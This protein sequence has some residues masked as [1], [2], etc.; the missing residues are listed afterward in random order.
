MKK[1]NIFLRAFLIYCLILILI[2]GAGLLVLRSFL[3]SYEASRPD[4]TVEEFMASRDHDFWLDGLQELIDAGFNEFTL[5]GAMLSDFGI[6]ENAEIS[7]RSNASDSKTEQS[8]DVRLGSSKICTLLLRSSNNVGFGLKSWVVSDWEFTMPGGADIRLS[9]PTGC[10]AEIN[11]VAVSADYITDVGSISLSLEHDFDIPPA[12]EIYEI[13]GMMGPA[14][15]KAFDADG[16]EL[17]AASVSANHV[18]FLPEPTQE[19]SFLALEGAEVYVNGQEITGNYCSPLDL[20][21]EGESSILRYE[22]QGLFGE[23]DIRVVQDE[24]L[25]EAIELPVGYCYIPGASEEIEGN[26]SEFLEGFIY[27]YVNFSANKDH[28]AEGNFAALSNYLLP[29]SELYTLIANTIENIAW[30]TTS[31][32][33]YNSISYFDLIPLGDERYICSIAYD[34]S[35]TLGP[36]ELEVKDGNLILV[37]KHDGRYRV[38]AMSAALQ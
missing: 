12:A 38:A 17:E 23:P 5:P 9:V 19:F 1:K 3:K 11:G 24:E 32:L 7:W 22:C 8:Y 13:K 4:N 6:D 14:D 18:E 37:E 30:A 2:I 31:G 29:G 35:Y 28:N 21:L 16:N 33:E 15:I 20:G 26:L 10:T 27:A 25:V 34:I 36:D